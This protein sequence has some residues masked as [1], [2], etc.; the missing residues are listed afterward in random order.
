MELGGF[1]RQK[2]QGLFRLFCSGHYY[3]SDEER[4]VGNEEHGESDRTGWDGM[5]DI[6]GQRDQI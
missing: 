6:M 1:E 4:G 5:V 3:A 2:K